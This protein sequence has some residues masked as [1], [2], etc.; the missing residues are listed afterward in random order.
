MQRKGILWLTGS[1]AFSVCISVAHAGDTADDI[2]DMLT[3]WE[4]VGSDWQEAKD[5]IELAGDAP[6]H[7][8]MLAENTTEGEQDE[9]QQ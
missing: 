7:P 6:V 3:W 9:R 2:T 5:L 4:K 1:L 8:Y